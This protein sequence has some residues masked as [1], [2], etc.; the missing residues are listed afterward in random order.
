MRL[1]PL[2][3]LLVACASAPS[4]APQ[5]PP[6]RPS[7]SQPP[8]SASESAAPEAAAGRA[9]AWRRL[10]ELVAELDLLHHAAWGG[11]APSEAQL[12]ALDHAAR[13][14]LLGARAL[15]DPLGCEGCVD[16]GD[17]LLRTDEPPGNSAS[18][19]LM[20]LGRALET[21][22]ARHPEP[23][24]ACQAERAWAGVALE[25]LARAVAEA[26]EL[27]E[28]FAVVR[29]LEDWPAEL[30]RIHAELGTIEVP[31]DG[32]IRAEHEAALSWVASAARACAVRA[33]PSRGRGGRGP[34]G[35]R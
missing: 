31:P 3:V 29:S 26:P 34:R 2:A 23:A 25:R 5:S 33:T 20:S 27:E 16:D 13:V 28:R 22:L 10:N 18:Y 14:A 9:E 11:D 4:R 19:A 8:P 21:I 7:P 15:L 17:L 24:Y 32:A 1:A 6:S 30:E 12:V 35:T